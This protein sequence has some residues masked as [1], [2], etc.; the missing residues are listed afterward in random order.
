M[1]I[2]ELARVTATKVETIR[3]Y[4]KGGLLSLPART[5]GN[6]RDRMS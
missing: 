4:E 2:G 6:Y 1:K 5:S 3:H